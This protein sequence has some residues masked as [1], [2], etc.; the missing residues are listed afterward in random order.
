MFNDPLTQVR[1]LDA[2][3]HVVGDAQGHA[4]AQPPPGRETRIAQDQPAPA[5]GEAGRLIGAIWTHEV[6][7]GV[8]SGR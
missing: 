2:D 4:V 5:M 8:R 7:L 6:A 3:D 1:L